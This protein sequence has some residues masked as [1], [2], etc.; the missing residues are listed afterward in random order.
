MPYGPAIAVQQ[1]AHHE[2]ILRAVGRSV[3]MRET[4]RQSSL[5][6]RMARQVDC[7]FSF[8]SP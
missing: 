1:L 7:Y 4:I 3:G 5:R 2:A 8:Q 6:S